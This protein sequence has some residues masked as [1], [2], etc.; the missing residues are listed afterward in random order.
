MKTMLTCLMS[1]LLFAP[2]SSIA[3][4]P[5]LFGVTLDGLPIVE[6]RL[7]DISNHIGKKP[8]L[9]V[10]F[11]QWPESP[12]RGWFPQETFD[13]ILRFGA[14]PCLTWEPMYYKDDKEHMIAAKAITDGTFD[15]YIDMMASRL[16]ALRKPVYLRFGHEMNLARY[17]W[18]V[19][20]SQYNEKAPLAYQSMYRHIRNRFRRLKADNVKFVFC[21]NAESQPHPVYN[22]ATWNTASAYFPG[23]SDVDIFGMDG[24]NWG[25][26][27]T[28]E[29]HGWDSTFRS[30]ADIF[31]PLHEELTRLS[32]NTPIFVFE[33]ASADQGGDKTL[34]LQNAIATMQSWGIRGFCWFEANKE[35][36]WRLDEAA[37]AILT[38]P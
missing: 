2:T 9:V 27:Q 1:I 28:K 11:L 8:S 31:S 7:H 14:I 32:K 38:K 18:G 17:H 25:T 16:K 4:E 37:H 6:S 24:Y 21:P 13:A 30:F 20:A 10:F 36:D 26:T 35:V 29:Q 23:K 15:S 33:T 3:A 5:L 22:G 12:T 19:S 34:W